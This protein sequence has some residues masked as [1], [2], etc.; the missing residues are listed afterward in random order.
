M[1]GVATSAANINDY[2]GLD[3]YGWSYFS[4][5]GT[6]YNGPGSY[7]L[8]YGDPWT[9]GDVIGIA[10]DANSGKIYF[11]KNCTWQNFSN[12]EMGLSPAFSGISGEVYPMVGGGSSGG[13]FNNIN[14]ANF[15]Q[16]SFSCAVP[17]GFTAGW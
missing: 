2:P 16:S 10:Y 4:Y 13:G 9:A 8:A 7:G 5:D 11:S 14:T 17:N 12:P 1:Y 6:L 15:G 3:I